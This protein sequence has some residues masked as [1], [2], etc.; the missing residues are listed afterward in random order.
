MSTL[1]KEGRAGALWPGVRVLALWVTAWTVMEMHSASR[2]G[3]CGGEKCPVQEIDCRWAFEGEEYCLHPLLRRPAS[4]HLASRASDP[5]KSIPCRKTP[6]G[7]WHGPWHPASAC[8]AT[9]W[10]LLKSQSAAPTLL[11]LIQAP[12]L[13]LCQILFPHTPTLS[14]IQQ[15]SVAKSCSF[16]PD[17]LKGSSCTLCISNRSPLS[18]RRKG[19]QN[20]NSEQKSR[21]ANGSAGQCCSLNPP[22]KREVSHFSFLSSAISF[23]LFAGCKREI[24]MIHKK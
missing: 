5:W 7:P 16:T 6:S 4:A 9:R 13:M 8:N 10:H 14:P 20:S 18:R 3:G 22:Q 23:S 11:S 24:L 1:Q 19:E 2:G 17:F 15:G 12:P 21:M